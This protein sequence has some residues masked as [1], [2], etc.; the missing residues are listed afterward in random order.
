MSRCSG[1]EL[2]EFISSDIYNYDNII[3]DSYDYNSY[4]DISCR[5]ENKY[6]PDSVGDPAIEC[7]TL[8]AGSYLDHVRSCVSPDPYNVSWTTGPVKIKITRQLK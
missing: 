5:S 2:T 3:D 8:M 4:E 1:L 6:F 7:K